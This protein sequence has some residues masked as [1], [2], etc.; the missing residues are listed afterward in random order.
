M[1]LNLTLEFADDVSPEEVAQ[2]ILAASRDAADQVAHGLV[3]V[4]ALGTSVTVTPADAEG[5]AAEFW[6]SE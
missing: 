2:A 3:G 1:I 4:P 5:Y 6:R